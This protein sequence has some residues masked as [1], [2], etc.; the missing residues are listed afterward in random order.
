MT[1]AAG[2]KSEWGVNEQVYA[3][4]VNTTLKTTQLTHLLI[5]S[6]PT[7]LKLSSARFVRLLMEEGISPINL[8]PLGRMQQTMQVST[9]N[10]TS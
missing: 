10:I 2:R 9:N 5:F 1:R 6:L 3:A 8:L 7:Y 4:W